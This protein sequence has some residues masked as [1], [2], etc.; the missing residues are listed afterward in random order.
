GW[1][2]DAGGCALGEPSMEPHEVLPSEAQE[3]MLLV[4]ERGKLD[5]VLAVCAKWGVLATAIGYVTAPPG[6][7]PGRLVVNWH[8]QSVVD[9]PPGSLADDGPVYARPMPEPNDPW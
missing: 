2:C 7:G 4:V 3:R 1:A 8:G 6:G 5:A 9:V